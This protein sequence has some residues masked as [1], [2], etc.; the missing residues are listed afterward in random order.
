[1]IAHKP[2]RSDGA[3]FRQNYSHAVVCYQQHKLTEFTSAK[4][5]NSIDQGVW[6]G[7]DR[8]SM[9]TQGFIHPLT[10]L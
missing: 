8:N 5:E 9:L 1:M 7:N 2:P 4:R 6:Q 3:Q 10:V